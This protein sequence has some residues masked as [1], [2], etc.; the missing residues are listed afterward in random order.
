MQGRRE[1]ERRSESGSIR[2]EESCS[3]EVE[4]HE[5]YGHIELFTYNSGVENRSGSWFRIVCRTCVLERESESML[6]QMSPILRSR[7]LN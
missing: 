5:N 4:H 2:V 1:A 6:A 7:L 3:T